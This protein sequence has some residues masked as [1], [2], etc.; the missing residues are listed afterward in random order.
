MKITAVRHGETMGNVRHIVESRTGGK[1]DSLGLEQAK[2]VADQLRH[3]RFQAA[4]SSDLHRCIETARAVVAPHP[5][6]EITLTKRLRERNQGVYEGRSWEDLP[7]FEFEGENLAAEIPGGESWLGVHRRIGAFI[8]DIYAQ[9]S[10]AEVLFV[11]HGGPIKSLRAHLGGLSLG[12]SVDETVLNGTV[13][14]WEMGA[15][16]EL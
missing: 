12:Q 13:W 14:R 9:H 15:P 6:L 3:G 5:G 4:Y 1:L 11:T 8:N 10:E 7:W 2:A 16:V